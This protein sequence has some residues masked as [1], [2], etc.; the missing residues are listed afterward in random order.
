MK[1]NK[2]KTTL[3]NDVCLDRTIEDFISWLTEYKTKKEA[4]GYFDIYMEGDYEY[5]YD[6]SR[7]YEISIYGYRLETDEELAKRV[8]TSK[9]RSVAAK[10]AAKTKALNKEKRELEIYNRLAEK[11]GEAKK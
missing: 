5:G 4:E 2:I 3:Y 8:A 9:A 6:S 10:K 11:Y 7:T 1:K